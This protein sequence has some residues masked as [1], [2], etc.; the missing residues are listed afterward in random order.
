MTTQTVTPTERA[1]E[2]QA[3]RAHFIAGLR[4]FADWLT[5]N[6]WAPTM[7]E[8]GY[9][10]HAR[11]QIDFH[12][13]NGDDATV[14]TIARVRE[15]ADRLGVKVDESLDDRT[16]AS[17]EIGAVSY[18]VIAW[19]RNGRPDPR[20]AEL[21]KLRARVAE[22]EGSTDRPD[23]SGLLYTRADSEG[24]P[25]PVSPARGLNVGAVVADGELVDETP[26][27]RNRYGEEIPSNEVCVASLHI[28]AP[29]E[30][31]GWCGL[32]DM[33]SAQHVEV[34][35]TASSDGCSMECACGVTFS[36]F[37]SVAEASAEL[38]VHI[39]NAE[40]ASHNATAEAR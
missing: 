33:R 22:L 19:H 20:D 11:L 9:F 36:G 10:Q 12:G 28:P 26:V 8:S 30:F 7:R 25:T 15:I 13:P 34:A 31:C 32:Q 39:R 3:K 1:D 29:G 14:D 2:L 6:P 16:D 4:E 5:E 38:A 18:S 40:S 21:V 27:Y 24:D 37:D 17:I 35:G 23:P